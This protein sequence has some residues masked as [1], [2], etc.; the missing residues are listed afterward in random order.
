MEEEESRLLPFHLFLG[1]VWV[2]GISGLNWEHLLDFTSLDTI[3]QRWNGEPLIDFT[4]F[5]HN[6]AHAE[7]CE[8]KASEPVH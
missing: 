5:G 7:E 3:I 4:S 1:C 6:D 8:V 2:G